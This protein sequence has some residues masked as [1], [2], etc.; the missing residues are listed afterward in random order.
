MAN[1]LES[2]MI[3]SLIRP[4]DLQDGANNGDY[5]SLK[6]YKH[7]AIFFHSAIGT[8]G[9]DPTINLNQATD[10]SG[11]SAKSLSVIDTIYVKQ[12]ATSLASTGT[13]SKV[14]QSAAAT[15]TEATSAEEEAMWVVEI[16]ADELDVDNG[17]DC[18]QL[19]VADVGSNAQLGAA[20]A[21]LTEPR[22]PAAAENMLSAIE[23]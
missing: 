22:F 20:Y 12:A 23:D 3:V 14:T 13:F 6:N 18:V 2:V 7:V 11:T 8:A 9:D 19:T 21:F 4:V 17:F 5:V 16:D 10:V 15:Y 1:L